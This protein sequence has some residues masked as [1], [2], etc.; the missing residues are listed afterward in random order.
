MPTL[1]ESLL[2]LK[3][4]T[5]SHVTFGEVVNLLK[6][7]GFPIFLILFSFPFCLPIQIPGMSTPFGI[8]LMFMGLRLA[9]GKKMWWPK[10]WLKKEVPSESLNKIIDSSLNVVRKM[11]RWIKPRFVFLSQNE[12]MHRL[13]GLLVTFL[14]F[15]LAL[16][17]PIPFTNMMSAFPIIFLGI[18]MLEDDGVFI[19]IAYAWALLTAG[20]YIGLFF[21][22]RH[23]L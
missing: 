8:A 5:K 4:E 9:F 22:G 20:F 7:R 6:G 21:A 3:E 1:E 13:H 19:I 12:K 14:A 16:P 10:S 15:F 11:E 2:E 17:L 18:G 23:F